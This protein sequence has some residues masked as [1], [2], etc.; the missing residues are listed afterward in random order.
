[1]AVLVDLPDIDA[2]L[3]ILTRLLEA[4]A[5]PVPL[6]DAVLRISASVGV[7]SYPQSAEV[8]AD[9][10]LRQADQ[11][12]YQAK[13]TGK[14]R[15]HLFDAEQDRSVRDHHEL[16]G[17]MRRAL[18]AGEFELYYQPK[19]NMGSGELVGAE[20]L[21]RWNH[22]QR[23]L[24]SPG[25]FLPVLEDHPLSI[26]VG[27]WVLD[28]A[29]SQVETWHTR[30]LSLPVS[31]NVGARQLQHPDFVP[32]L[33]GLLARHP[34][35]RAG[36]LELEILETSALED[37]PRVSRVMASCRELG[38]DFALDDFGTGYSSLLYLKQLPVSLIKLDQ[39]FVCNMH[40]NADDL[41]I[42]EGVLGLA[43]AFRR[44]LMAEGVE[45]VAQGELLLRMGCEW[46]QGY[47]IARPLPARD[48]QR[49]ADS[50]EVPSEWKACK[51]IRRDLL[52]I[53]F[54][55]VDHRAWVAAMAAYLEGRSD[56]PPEAG[57]PCCRMGQWLDRAVRALLAET[58]SD[59]PVDS[60]HEAIHHLADELV[61]LRWAGRGEEARDRLGELF[62][63]RDRMLERLKER[64][65]PG[66]PTED[67]AAANRR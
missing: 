32:H 29:L 54:A 24:L 2:S 18:G 65:A 66:D 58:G 8:D 26:D 33:R 15:F 39:S 12:M 10:L 62:G 34:G 13:Q 51:P 56:T 4:A 36:E 27:E 64:Y 63:L 16:L 57:L 7:T 19:V 47:A 40:D 6:G 42:L 21:I 11:A 45:T 17:Q 20:A 44:R 53:L 49:W 9:Q 23:G 28:T 41:A 55:A 59:R 46:A 52:P 43:T 67:E 5:Q 60:L 30:G 61:A 25:A 1:M 14:N 3:P 38:V 48:F 31:V 50:W 22:P 37:F 35:V